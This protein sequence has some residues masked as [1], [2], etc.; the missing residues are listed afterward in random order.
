MAFQNARNYLLDKENHLL[1]GYKIITEKL[2]C[3]SVIFLNVTKIEPTLFSLFMGSA[4]K[5]YSFRFGNDDFIF[6]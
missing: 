6:Q 2:Y 3:L 4:T 5:I 1:H